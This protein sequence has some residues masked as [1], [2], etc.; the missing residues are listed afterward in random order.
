MSVDQILNSHRREMASR[1]M[2]LLGQRL[3]I[4]ESFVPLEQA[5]LKDDE[6][7]AL[8]HEVSQITETV[9]S[10]GVANAPELQ[11]TVETILQIGMP[12]AQNALSALKA[13]VAESCPSRNGISLLLHGFGPWLKSSGP[14]LRGHFLEVLPRISP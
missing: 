9:I 6:L 3:T 14:S 13:A 5:A 8:S 10:T 11:K 2:T 12:D 7:A 4:Y 1:R